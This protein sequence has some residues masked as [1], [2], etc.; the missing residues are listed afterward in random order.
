MRRRNDRRRGPILA[1]AVVSALG[2][3]CAA[4]AS[5]QVP[6]AAD[7]TGEPQSRTLVVDG[8]QRHYTVLRPHARADGP[9]GVLLVLHGSGGN[10][11][12]IREM[13]G[14]RLEP[15]AAASGYAVV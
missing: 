4:A 15:L 5:P 3:A 9:A 14:R 13:L 6:P 10:G 1:L 11:V 7:E 2:G 12:Q 8:Q